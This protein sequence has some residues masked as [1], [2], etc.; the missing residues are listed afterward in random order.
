MIF[1]IERSG[2]SLIENIQFHVK[3]K[4]ITQVAGMFPGTCILWYYWAHLAEVRLTA[5]FLMYKLPLSF[6]HGVNIPFLGRY[7]H[8]S[9]KPACLI[10]SHCETHPSVWAD[11]E[12]KNDVRGS[13][14]L[15]ESSVSALSPSLLLQ[16]A[17]PRRLHSTVC[18]PIMASFRVCVN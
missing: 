3:K 1:L 12:A 11:P 6:C 13:N 15:K 17:L 5:V 9:A 7:L 10:R 4:R 16:R 14:V 8:V 18:H 2:L